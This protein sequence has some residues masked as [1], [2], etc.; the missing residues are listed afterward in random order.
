MSIQKKNFLEVLGKRKTDRIPF[1]FMRQAGRYLPE[2][3]EL[4]AKAGSF[5]DLAYNP[6]YASEVT[7][8][9]IRRYGM[10]A[11][12][13]FSDILVIPHALGQS[14]DFVQGEG[15]KLD[16]LQNSAD[17]S[18]LN[19]SKFEST[20][21]PVYEALQKTKAG[22]QNEGHHGTALI[23][24][25]GAPWTVACY[26]V[27]GGGSKEFINVKKMAYSDPEGFAALIELLVE[28]SAQYLINQI[29]AGAEAVQIFDSW[30]GALDAQSFNKWVVKPTRQI[31]DLVRNT[32]PH[33]P[34]IGFPRCAG[35]NYFNYI[36]NTG[37]TAV[38]LDTSVDTVWA[39]RML[40]PLVPVQGN[41]DPIC[42]LTGGDA[43][44]LAAE[45]IMGDLSAG[46][47][48]FNLGHGINK[49]TPPEHVEA[50][51]NFIRDYK[52]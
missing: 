50:L 1:W 17:I 3:R 26:M 27:E 10:D 5:L 21:N 36:Q 51:A 37:V 42:L 44:I 20:L 23:G 38:S 48:I 13:I 2:Y 43:M 45:K 24:F 35:A 28:S 16:A 9:P 32:H 11:A 30:A 12:I 34:I 8:Q 6:E 29:N 25:C 7:L 15:P 33:V 14:L 52:I 18:R 46:G 39:A 31:V 41:L 19:F 4:R 40:Q 22:L 47:F 49:D